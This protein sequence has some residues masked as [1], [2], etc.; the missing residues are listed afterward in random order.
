VFE[1]AGSMKSVEKQARSLIYSRE[2]EAV[3]AACD[4]MVAWRG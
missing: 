1:Q 2:R 4:M 3:P